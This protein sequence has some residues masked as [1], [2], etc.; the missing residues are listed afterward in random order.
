MSTIFLALLTAHLLGDFVL[1]TKRQV[2]GKRLGVHRAFLEHGL[3][4]LV[5]AV[6][7]LLLFALQQAVTWRAGVGVVLL[8]A[9]HLALDGC[10]EWFGRFRELSPSK[11]AAL[12]LADQSAHV[13]LVLLAAA[14]IARPRPG[15]LSAAFSAGWSELREPLLV[16]LPIYLVVVF[17]GGFL[18]QLLLGPFRKPEDE[19]QH[20]MPNAGLYIGWLERAIVMTALAAGEQTLVGFV[21]AAKA[22]IRFKESEQAFAEY[23]L[24]GTFLS[25]LLAG[26][27]AFAM[28][29]AGLFALP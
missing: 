5:A 12:F 20:G 21:I 22:I 19:S 14:V 13:L 6:L 26:A 4:H 28:R 16:T 17:G 27:G 24:L 11:Q 7:L 1:Q 18:I 9:G 23:F 10:K 2:E 15:A 3:A 25:L 29:A 8:V